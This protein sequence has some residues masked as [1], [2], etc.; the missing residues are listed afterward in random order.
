MNLFD[1]YREAIHRG[2]PVKDNCPWVRTMYDDYDYE[3]CF[4]HWLTPQEN[5]GKHHV[6]VDVLDAEGF[7]RRDIR[8]LMLGWS[9]QFR[10]PDED[11]PPQRLDKR[12]PEPAGNLPI[13]TGQRLVVWLQNSSGAQV[14]QSVGNLHTD[15]EDSR[16]GNSRFHHSY[17][18]VFRPAAPITQPPPRDGLNLTP[19]Q[20]AEILR[21][22]ESITA[23]AETIRIVLKGAQT[24]ALGTRDVNNARTIKIATLP[25]PVNPGG[26][27]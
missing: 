24:G 13:W 26:I 10:R 18:V 22:V 8:D 21:N 6:Y 7:P 16:P 23:N 19:A 20:L 2:N 17:Y 9:W 11:A 4:V 15:M 14:S 3:A 27:L 12:E 5:G 1:T 25:L